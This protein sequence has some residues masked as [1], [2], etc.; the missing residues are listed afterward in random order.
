MWGK[1]L[2]VKGILTA[3]DARRAV[4]CGADAIVVSNHGGRQL[5][6]APAT[7]H[8]LPE[9]AAAIGDSAEILLDSGVRRGNDVLKALAL[10]ARAVLVGRSV[11]YGLAVA[12]ADG[13]SWVLDLLRTDMVRS[14]R[15]MG[16]T[17]VDA[18]DASWVENRCC[19]TSLN[20]LAK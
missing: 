18:A 16:L 9:I 13:V 17:S 7:V 3:D 5:E 8:V 10:G 2:V 12:G 19:R 11:V 14:M 6:S 15:L 20:S 4:D 1:P